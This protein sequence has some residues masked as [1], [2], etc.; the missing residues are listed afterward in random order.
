VRKSIP[1]TW[2][3]LELTEGKNR[4]V[5]RM[6]AAVGHPTL[7]LLRARIGNFSLGDLAPGKW[8][9]LTAAERTAVFA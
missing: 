3:A 1:D 4:Q 2:L 7:R 8:R 9:E 6:T 5:R